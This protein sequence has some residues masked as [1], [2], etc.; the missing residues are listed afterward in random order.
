MLG[1]SG[2]NDDALL[3]LLVAQADAL[4]KAYTDRDLE[5]RSYPGAVTGGKGDSGYYSSFDSA[6]LYLRQ[7]PVTAVA[8]IYYDPSGRFDENPD[9]SFAAATLMT[10][11][12]EYLWEKDGCLPGGTTQCSYS[13]RVQ[14]IAGVW[15]M[16]RVYRQG[17][18]TLQTRELLGGIKVAY[19]AGY[20]TIPADLESAT[21]DVV[22]ALYRNRR[23]GGSVIN[24]SLGG[25]SYS[26]GGPGG[27]GQMPELA[28]ARQKLAKYRRVQL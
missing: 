6:F 13:G 22:A 7:T 20:T 26:L 15:P 5:S 3:T 8:S 19:T 10:A 9:G 23:A 21:L 2:S 24:E 11:G 16:T 27:A 25:Y 14:R 18:I 28:S 12:T 17:N 4:V 1:I